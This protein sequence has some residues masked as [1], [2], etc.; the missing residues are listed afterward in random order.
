M[1]KKKTKKN[2]IAIGEIGKIK[3]AQLK[4]ME[5]IIEH[6]QAIFEYQRLYDD[7]NNELIRLADAVVA[8][9]ISQPF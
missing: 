5:H 4:L 3:Q 7:Q 2:P 9:D 1:K 6:L 8:V